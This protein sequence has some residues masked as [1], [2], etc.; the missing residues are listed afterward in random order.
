MRAYAAD[1]YRFAYWLC[2]DRHVAEDVVQ[3]ACLRAWRSWTHLR[4]SA[5]AKTWLMTIARNE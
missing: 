2:S 3:E 1:L 5:H 4:D